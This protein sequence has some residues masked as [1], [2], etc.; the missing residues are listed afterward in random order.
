MEFKENNLRERFHV[1]IPHSL[2]FSHVPD[3]CKHLILRCWLN[4]CLLSML[5]VKSISL[6]GVGRE[7]EG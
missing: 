1:K 4:K 6:L 7:G 5:G 3:P 2:L